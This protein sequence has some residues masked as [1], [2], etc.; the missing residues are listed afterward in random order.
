MKTMS[1]LHE[2]WARLLLASIMAVVGVAF[3]A[4]TAAGAQESQTAGLTAEQRERFILKPQYADIWY[5]KADRIYLNGYWKFK[6]ALNVL[7]R[8]NG[9]VVDQE[10]PDPGQDEGLSQGYF[11]PDYDASGWGEIAV[12]LPWNQQLLLGQTAAEAALCRDR[13]L[14]DGV[15][16]PRRPQGQAR[17]S[18]VRLRPDLL[19]GVAQWGGGGPA[20]QR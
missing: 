5:G 15:H 4:P 8:E 17:V 3:L 11:R 14:P 19:S 1:R 12:P 9:Q 2:R 6:E 20:H 16:G 7:K 18:A 10:V 13:L